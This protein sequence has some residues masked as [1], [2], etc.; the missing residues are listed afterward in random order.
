L[1]LK[2]DKILNISPHKGVLY[3]LYRLQN[4]GEGIKFLH[5]RYFL[6]E[7]HDSIILRNKRNKL[8][9]D[10]KRIVATV[11]NYPEAWEHNR[12]AVYFLNPK[13][14]GLRASTNLSNM[15]NRLLYKRDL[16]NK[17][18]GSKPSYYLSWFGKV[19]F[20]RFLLD[21]LLDN[22]CSEWEIQKYI[23]E[24]YQKLYASDGH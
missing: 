19:M 3:L 24:I 13:I 18:K 7:N 11:G 16:I 9:K 1:E 15:L 21:Y 4:E 10:G 20:Q 12:D 14:K 17:S 23:H 5:L 22:Y 2:P 6:I 8:T